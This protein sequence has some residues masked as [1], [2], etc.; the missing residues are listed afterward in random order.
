MMEEPGEEQVQ[1]GL[2]LLSGLTAASLLAVFILRARRRRRRPSQTS[3]EKTGSA[4]EDFED[5]N[6]LLQTDLKNKVIDR[7]NQVKADI[8]ARKLQRDQNVSD[9]LT[10]QEKEIS[11]KRSE[12]EIAKEIIEYK[13]KEKID[14]LKQDVKTEILEMKE[15]LKSLRIILSSSPALSTTETM[16]N[17]KSELEC[18][19]CLEEMRPP[20]R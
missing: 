17:T 2:L 15:S 12:F 6:S 4:E 20:R 18:P 5:I 11:E 14:A 9:L 1:A 8:K 16:S 10:D 13:Y 19:V 7:I 3:Q